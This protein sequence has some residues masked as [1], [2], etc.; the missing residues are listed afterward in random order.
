MPR[1]TGL[2]VKLNKTHSPFPGHHLCAEVVR[3]GGSMYNPHG[4]DPLI[5]YVDAAWLEDDKGNKVRDL[6][7]EE[8]QA[9]DGE[10][11]PKAFV[12]AVYETFHEDEAE[13][14]PT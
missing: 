3:D 2:E 10:K 8:I 13:H 9:L 1:K 14:D 11:S 5:W 7:N 6:T 12:D 4:D